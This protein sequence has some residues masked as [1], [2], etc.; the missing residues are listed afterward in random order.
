MNESRRDSA[1]PQG[2]RVRV[3][4]TVGHVR[5]YLWLRIV[6]PYSGEYADYVHCEFDSPSVLTE[7][8]EP[9]QSM[10]VDIGRIVEWNN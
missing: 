7:F 9:G 10:M 3:S 8:A 6:A 1:N 5:E 4:W 2:G